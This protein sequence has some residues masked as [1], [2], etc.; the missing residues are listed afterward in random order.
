VQVLQAHRLHF[1]QPL[2]PSLMRPQALLLLLLLLL[3][4]PAAGTSS[5]E[6]RS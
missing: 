4:V 2:L 5:G 6:A 1:L 3:L